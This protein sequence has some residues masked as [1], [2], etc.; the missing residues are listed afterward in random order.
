MN[1]NANYDNGFSNT[2][3]AIIG[4]L[5]RTAERSVVVFWD[6]LRN[7]TVHGTPSLLGFVSAI[8]P[9][10]APIPIA[11]QT[12]VSLMKFMDWLPFQAIIMAV[13]IEAAGFVLWVFLTESIM[14]DGWKATTTQYT[15]GIAVLVYQV[16][17]ILINVGLAV[18]EGTRGTM[19]F[20]LFLAC[21]F[22]ALCSIA[23]GYG[24]RFNQAKLSQESQEAKELAERER[25]EQK[26][27]Q[28]REYQDRLAI[29]ERIRQ[30]ER[31]DALARAE[32]KLKYAA[33]TGQVK[34][35]KPFRGSR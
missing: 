6:G 24:N 16:V 35:L 31:Q 11:T 12:A 23:Y 7:T 26:E 21:L 19:A 27:R 5:V 13:V 8:A 30:E 3:V 33:E 22:P 17:L 32:L 9:V 15:F 18:E 20:I 28:E 14:A 25:Q 34:E 10:L 29:E 1:E 4:T 2:I